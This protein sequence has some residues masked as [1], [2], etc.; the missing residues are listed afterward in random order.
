MKI[1]KLIINRNK[2]LK[3]NIIKTKIYKR[4]YL[5]QNIF[6]EDIEHRLKKAL[7]IIHLFHK[8]NKSIVF[9]G[10]SIYL[11]HKL[12]LFFKNTNHSVIPES[13][14]KNGCLTN[15]KSNLKHF[16]EHED[17]KISKILFN[18]LT[19][20]PDLVVILNNESNINV[21]NESYDVKIPIVSLSNNLNLYDL[22]SNYKVPGDFK[23]TNKHIR[24][25]IFFS[26]LVTTLKK[27]KK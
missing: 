24:D 18:F 9:V 10:S 15:N 16:F 19:K 8:N 17:V 12:N 2:L 6:I 21:L 7:K 27:R 14:W 26:L 4:P 1:K 13:V 3:L 25:N 11:A 22:K 23:F 20:K 5:F